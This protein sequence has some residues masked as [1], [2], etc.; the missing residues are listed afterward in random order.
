MPEERTLTEADIKAIREA[1]KDDHP[2]KMGID[3]DE[4]E[5]VWPTVKGM[6]ENIQT[7]QKI[8]Y[9]ILITALVMTVIGW[10]G[11]GIV[12][13]IIAAVKTGQVTK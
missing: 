6:A 2:C 5:A 12:Q 7:A 4:F 10:I 13:S 11:K 3:P 8:T 1:F 9:K